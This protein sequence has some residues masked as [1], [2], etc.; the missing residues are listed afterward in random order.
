MYIN[1][2]HSSIWSF[3]IKHVKILSERKPYEMS[4][5]VDYKERQPKKT[6]N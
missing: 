6:C 1:S 4:L 2:L 5:E 3:R